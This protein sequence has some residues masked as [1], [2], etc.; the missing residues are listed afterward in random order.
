[1]RLILTSAGLS[2]SILQDEFLNLL[3]KPVEAVKAQVFYVS[4]EDPGFDSMLDNVVDQLFKVGIKKENLD[5]FDL[6]GDTPPGLKD[7]DLVLIFGGNEYH[8]MYHIRRLG[9]IQEIRR[10]VDGDGVYIGVSAGS[11][12]MGPDVDVDSW[13]MATNDLGLDDLSGF[14]YVDFTTVAHIEWRPNPEKALRHHIE[15]G[16]KMIYFT[17]KQGVFVRDCGYRIIG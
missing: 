1:M 14:G 10:F 17:D 5:S 15:T 9:L 4:F 11:I 2:T 7:R 8:Y 13:S 6:T 3:T 16:K 12:I